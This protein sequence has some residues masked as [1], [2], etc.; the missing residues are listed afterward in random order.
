MKRSFSQ[1]SSQTPDLGGHVFVPVPHKIIFSGVIGALAA[2]GW[3]GTLFFF[4]GIILMRIPGFPLPVFYIGIFCLTGL[5]IYIIFSLLHSAERDAKT[6]RAIIKRLQETRDRYAETLEGSGSG[7]WEWSFPEQSV[8][9][10][11]HWADLFGYNEETAPKTID[12]WIAL[13]HEEDKEA[14]KRMLAYAT[15]ANARVYKISY[16]LHTHGGDWRFVIDEGVIER[17]PQK[18]DHLRMFGSTRDMTDEHDAEELLKHRTEELRQAN[19][20]VKEEM[21]NTRKFEQAVAAASDAIVITDPEGVI[22]YGNTSWESLTGE[23]PAHS[24]GM[25]FLSP[26]EETTESS[27]IRAVRQALVSRTSYMTDRLVGI[28]PGDTIPY[29]TELSLFPVT[30][31]NTVLFYAA[32]FS[33]VTKRKAVDKAKTE[34]VSLASHQLRT[35]LSAIRWYAEMLLSD[36]A[37]NLNPD[38]HMY[39]QEIYDANKRMVELVDA[40]LNVSRLDLGTMLWRPEPLK[41]TETALAAIKEMR[42]QSEKKKITIGTFFSPDEKD[43]FFDRGQLFIIF[44]NLLSNAVKYTQEGGHIEVTIRP[45]GEERVFFSVKDNG[46]G[47]PKEQQPSIFQKMFRADNAKS[48]DTSGTGLGL[49]IIKN[50]VEHAGGSIRFDSDLGKGTVFY[51]I[52][53]LRA[54]IKEDTVPS[55]SQ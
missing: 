51:G 4:P 49:Y 22:V 27:D 32:I 10:S 52:L 2:L 28:R 33:D 36:M 12:A 21:R 18:N 5:I 6:S 35:P 19:E 26:F 23:T 45:E 11:E 34:F 24:I 46:C 38:Q 17:D 47:I 16:R 44:Q 15:G 1:S 25:S 55:T 31:N 3:G 48:I 7:T 54:E 8:H 43:I 40:L 30:E 37:G 39:L 42:S 53:P 50:I 20:R 9:V 41:M 14:V 29:N 13:V